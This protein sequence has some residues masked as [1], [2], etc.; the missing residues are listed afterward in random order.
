MVFTT[1]IWGLLMVRVIFPSDQFWE[2]KAYVREYPLNKHC[3]TVHVSSVYIYNMKAT[4]V[5]LAVLKQVHLCQSSSNSIGH[6]H[7]WHQKVISCDGTT[8]KW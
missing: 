6:G 3:L 7:E 1:H 8:R 4:S 5:S 2:C